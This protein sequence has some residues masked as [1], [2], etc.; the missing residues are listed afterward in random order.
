MSGRSD[1]GPSPLMMNIKI[2]GVV[3]G[4]LALYT[5]VANSI[6]QLE[7]VV[8]QELSFG[9]DVSTAELV[10]AGEDL[11]VG[12]GSLLLHFDDGLVVHVNL[13]GPDAELENAGLQQQRERVA[14]LVGGVHREVVGLIAVNTEDF[15]AA[16]ELAEPLRGREA[17]GREFFGALEIRHEFP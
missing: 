15:Q 13:A 4:T 10:S 17:S 11:F 12:A 7:S 5:G 9:S 8:P 16:S 2:V 3:L 1:S 14:D 6:P